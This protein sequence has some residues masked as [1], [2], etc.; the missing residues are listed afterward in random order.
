MDVSPRPNWNAHWLGQVSF[1]SAWK[2]QQDFACQIAAGERPETLLLLQHP[3]TYTFG[4]RGDAGNLLWDDATLHEKGV[5]VHWTDRGG[6]VTYHGPGQLVGYPLI[7][8]GR[9]DLSQ[10]IPQVDYIQYL[11]R[12]EEVIINSL[13]DLGLA[14]GQIPGMTG[15]WVQPDVASRCPQCPP[16]AKKSP[17]KIASIG[18]KVN[19][20]GISQHGFALNI[21][22]DMDYWEGIVACDLPDHPSVSLADLLVHP[23]TQDAVID[24]LLRNFESVF[25]VRLELSELTPGKFSD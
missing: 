25:N 15:V 19:A 20:D 5:E 23:P 7:K 4:R 14:S 18:V 6:D 8:L 9:V 13:A 21:D 1:K 16:D 3:H 17:S 11:R 12:L 10:R 22:P 24:T 2:L